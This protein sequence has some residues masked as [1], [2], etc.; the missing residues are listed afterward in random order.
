MHTHAIA[1]H[2]LPFGLLLLA[3]G[4]TPAQAETRAWNFR[5]FLD[6]REIGYHHFTLRGQEPER[7]LKSEARF[8]VELLF[9]TAYRYAHDA[10]E[11]WRGNC[12]ADL[13]AQTDDNGQRYRLE[14]ARVGER[15]VVARNQGR[16]DLQGCV[17]TFAY[18]NPQMLSQGRLLNAQTGEYVDVTVTPIGE[19]TLRVRGQR[20]TARRYA[21]R[22]PN[23][24]IDLW[25]SPTNDWLALESTT[26]GGRRLR[27]QIN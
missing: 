5:V 17:M 24:A 3:L 9:F 15:L 19:E 10:T 21:L 13:K 11:R 2:W 22:G 7:E 4:I 23:L 27:Y 6:E 16:V 18:W 26:D 25:Y 1:R 20:V 8:N 14:A 12:L